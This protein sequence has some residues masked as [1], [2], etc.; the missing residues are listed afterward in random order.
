MTPGRTHYILGVPKRSFSFNTSVTT[1]CIIILLIFTCI[2]WKW[3]DSHCYGYI[4]D[5]IDYIDLLLYD[6]YIGSS[7]EIFGYLWKSSV[8][9][10]NF[11]KHSSGLRT[12]FDKSSE[13]FGKCSEIF[14]KSSKTSSLVC[15]YNTWEDLLDLITVLLKTSWSWI[16]KE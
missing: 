11:R 10:R 5:Y 4:I 7:S 6:W 2:N 14:G 13:I 1:F 15:L 16:V 3:K 12:T 8:I 9:F